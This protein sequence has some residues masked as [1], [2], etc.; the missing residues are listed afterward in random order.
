MEIKD[1]GPNHP[2]HNRHLKWRYSL[3]FITFAIF[4]WSGINPKDRATWVLETLP[5]MIGFTLVF[6]FW[7]RFPLSFLLFTLICIHSWILCVGGKY[8]Y[9]LV[10]IGDW[11][12]DF[13][14][15]ERNHYDRL[16]H[17]IQ[18]FEPAILAREI[19][20]RHRVTRSEAWTNFYAICFTLAFSAFYELIEWVTALILN[21]G[22]EAFLGTQGDIWDTQSDMFCALVG[23]LAAIFLL[24]RFHDHSIRKVID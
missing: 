24:R 23:A 15:F 5:S 20:I 17:L 12:R 19:L 6:I 22:A 7:R 11:F 2:W 8:T 4:I 9:A 1:A 3:L 18:G 10:P 21:Q 14:G 13:F 16:G